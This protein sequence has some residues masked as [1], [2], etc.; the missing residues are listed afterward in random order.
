MTK[1]NSTT[2]C[3][4]LDLAGN[5]FYF[6][7]ISYICIS[8]V[9]FPR[10]ACAMCVRCTYNLSD[11]FE[12]ILIIYIQCGHVVDWFFFSLSFSSGR[13]IRWFY[14]IH[15]FVL[16]DALI[17]SAT[18]RSVSHTLSFSLRYLYTVIYWIDWA[19]IRRHSNYIIT[20]HAMHIDSILNE[21]RMR[22]KNNNDCRWR[23]GHF[24]G[25]FFIWYFR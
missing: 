18:F 14:F 1:L 17:P 6:I 8:L 23:F 24:L 9:F 11:W 2:R 22:R 19:K 4:S 12:S 25:V 21:R 10:L 5:H 13:F 20:W 15:L 16:L 3:V 7:V